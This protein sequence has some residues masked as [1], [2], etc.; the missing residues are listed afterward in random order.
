MEE[1]VTLHEILVKTSYLT[2]ITEPEDKALENPIGFASGF[3]VEYE[4]DKFFIT[5]DHIVHFDDFVSARCHP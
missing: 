2:Q 5:A 4:N 3:I 1:S